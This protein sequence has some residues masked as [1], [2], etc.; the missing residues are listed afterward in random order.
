MVIVFQGLDF[1]V[2]DLLRAHERGGHRRV[3]RRSGPATVDQ[4]TAG[5]AAG[6]R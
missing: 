4:T 3:L 1:L 6:L 5:A 2:S